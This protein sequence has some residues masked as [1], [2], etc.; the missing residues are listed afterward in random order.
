MYTKTTP[1]IIIIVPLG[2]FMYIKNNA[3]YWQCCR[4]R[5]IILKIDQKQPLDYDGLLATMPI[6]N[7][8]ES[9]SDGGRTPH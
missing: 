4:N 5:D 9:T 6:I 2:G 3:T 1:P 8:G 7:Q